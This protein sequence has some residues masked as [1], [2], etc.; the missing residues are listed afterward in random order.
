MGFFDNFKGKHYKEES[1]RLSR[2]LEEAQ[3]LLTPEMRDAASLKEL[4]RQLETQ[5]GS[6]QN[7]VSDLHE[8]IQ[9][10]NMTIKEKKDTVVWIDETSLVQEFGLYEPQFEFAN[11]S[12]Y[13]D[14]L[15]RIRSD[16]KLMIK[17]GTAVSGNVDWTVNGN[18]AQG[19]KLVN[20]TR[21][22][23]L[24]AFNSECDEI[25]N[26]VRYT[27]YDSS[28]K[29]IKN[30]AEAI[31]KLGKVMTISISP[32]YLNSKLRE[33]KLAFE[34]QQTKQREKEELRE[35]RAE[36]REAA[37]LQKEID[38]Q[39]KV[40]EKEQRHYTAA[41]KKLQEQLASDPDNPDLLQKK[42]E[43]EEHLEDIDK[44]LKDIDYREANQKAGYVYVISNIG[45]FGSD[46][47]KIGM[48]RRLDPMD[49][50]YEL[51]DASV[52]FNFDVHAMIFSDNAPALEA[53]LHREFADRKLN[54][55]NQRR[56]F[57][58]VTL[59]EIKDV[60]N[61]NFDSTVEYVDVPDAEQYRISEK[62]R[63]Q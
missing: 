7:D 56:E 27:N 6:L 40:I 57:F 58:H 63:N 45:S 15:K 12:K 51:G 42:A 35:A 22:L 54:M 29:R 23:L 43:L 49:R 59:D 55:V 16:Q 44:N 18:K 5:R 13:K 50:V 17:N 24:R 3:E 19:R 53:A 36:M 11:S 21:K 14:E 41:Y 48:T 25:V 28:R 33:L 60:V 62:L 38:E 9:R 52:P 46:V 34:F 2:Q 31:S 37:K 26:K 4:I 32:Q 47:Y 8:E 61:R 1:E 10:L 20:D 39:R 30:S